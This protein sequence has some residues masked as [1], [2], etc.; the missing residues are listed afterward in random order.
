MSRGESLWCVRSVGESVGGE[1][2]VRFKAAVING[3][4]H[5]CPGKRNLLDFL[6]CTGAARG[7]LTRKWP[8]CWG[9]TPLDF[10]IYWTTLKPL[11]FHSWVPGFHSCF[12][13][14]R[15][16]IHFAKEKRCAHSTCGS[17]FGNKGIREGWYRHNPLAG[18]RV[19]PG[20]LGQSAPV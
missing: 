10:W 13:L 4:S 9:H 20:H 18:A 5:V 15:C 14:C 19:T 17:S 6:R 3:D 7:N 8:R 16:L 2:V 11:L 1:C 12:R